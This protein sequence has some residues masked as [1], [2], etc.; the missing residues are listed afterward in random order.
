MSAAASRAGPTVEAIPIELGLSAG[1]GRFG[2]LTFIAAFELKSSDSRFGGLSGLAV[3]GN[4]ERLYAIS[5]RGYWLSASMRHN[6]EGRLTVL[7]GWEIGTLLTPEGAPVSGLQ[8]DAES[9][10]QDRD[11]SFIVSFEQEHRLWRYP[12]SAAPFKGPSQTVPTPRE[13]SQAPNNGGI[14]ALTVL[15][16]GRIFAIAEE[17]ENPDGTL[18]AWLMD[19]DRFAALSYFSSA[20]FRP[21]D[22][23]TLANGDLL[24]LE[25]R[26]SLLGG[27]GA[28]VQRIARDSVRPGARLRGEEIARIVPPLPVDNYEGIAVREKEGGETFVYLVSDDN[29][30]PLQRTLLL[31]FRLD[32]EGQKRD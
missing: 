5:D 24:V 19:E 30:S 10:M 32:P 6:G 26:H 3:T 20:G 28:R 4:G 25:R 17:Y 14:E 23:T 9:L 31:Q 13:L 12:A 7:E 29:Y 2:S 8:T 22:M 16:D 15:R 21:T 18:K 11:G 1:R 27:W